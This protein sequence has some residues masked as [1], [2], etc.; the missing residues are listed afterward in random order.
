MLNQVF[1]QWTTP[2][3]G[4]QLLSKKL[5]DMFI[6]THHYKTMRYIVRWV[7]GWVGGYVSC[8]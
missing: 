7:H 1:N 6:S 4:V 3:K 8:T 2:S 5:F